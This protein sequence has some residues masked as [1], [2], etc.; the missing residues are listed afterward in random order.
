MDTFF[1]EFLIQTLRYLEGTVLATPIQEHCNFKLTVF[2][3][4]IF[5]PQ[6]Y[7]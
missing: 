2:Y 6:A 5:L 7:S 4:L 3:L 1:T